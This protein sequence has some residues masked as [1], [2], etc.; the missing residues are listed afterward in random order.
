MGR[1]RA[2]FTFH[3]GSWYGWLPKVFRYSRCNICDDAGVGFKWM[4]FYSYLRYR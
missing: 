1:L 2:S 4:I 3:L